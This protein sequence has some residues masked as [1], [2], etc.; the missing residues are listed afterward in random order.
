M[1][2][3]WKIARAEQRGTVVNV[4]S[5]ARAAAL[6]RVPFNIALALFEKE[7]GGQ[8]IYGKHDAGGALQGYPFPVDQGNY[9]VYR[10]LVLVQGHKSNGVGPGQVTW[11][12]WLREAER[13]GLDLW[14]VDDNMRL[15]LWILRDAK[16]RRGTWL[17]AAS[18]YNRNPDYPADLMRRA[19]EWKK[20]IRDGKP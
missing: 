3:A 11:P 14:D 10:W 19:R 12:G 20:F 13:R 2:A 9:Q 7:S 15:S 1:V 8:N 17:A 18:E 16:D 5:I 4:L 6:E